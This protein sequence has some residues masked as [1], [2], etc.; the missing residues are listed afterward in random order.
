[1]SL[2]DE[3]K[4]KLLSKPVGITSAI[5]LL[6]ISYHIISDIKDKQKFRGIPTPGNS[7][8]IVGNHFYSINFLFLLF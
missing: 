5:A 2:T 4:E 6:Y 7:Y 8:P 3:L 1:M